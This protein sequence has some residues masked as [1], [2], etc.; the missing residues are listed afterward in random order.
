MNVNRAFT[1]VLSFLCRKSL[2]CPQIFYVYLYVLPLLYLNKI[3]RFPVHM[4][5]GYQSFLIDD[6]KIFLKIALSK[7]STIFQEYRNYMQARE[8]GPFIADLLPTYQLINKLL[9]KAIKCEHLAWVDSNSALPLAVYI[10]HSFN[11]SVVLGQS[12]HLNECAE[13]KAGLNHVERRFG[14]KVAKKMQ[15]TLELFLLNGNYSVG[16]A[17]GDFHSRNI[18]VDVD[19]NPV[20][21]DLD[22]MRF[23]SIR[24]FDCLYFLLE[25]EWTLSGQIWIKT[26]TDCLCGVENSVKKGLESFGVIY[27]RE[28]ITAFFLDRVGQDVMRYRIVYSEK[29][30]KDFIVT[31]MHED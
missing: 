25:Q 16:I 29:N 5:R 10:N 8:C 18:M 7:R 11:K 27:S 26:L 15:H 21:V 22:C 3:I 6:G 1:R 13:L 12:L 17:H 20:I 30:L 4:K 2:T 31:F 14:I 19:K 9:I 23:K 24:E 28:L